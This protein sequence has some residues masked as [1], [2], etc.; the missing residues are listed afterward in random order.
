MRFVRAENAAEVTMKRN[1]V[2]WWLASMLLASVFG[3]PVTTLSVLW[4]VV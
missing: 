4:F 2:Y 1:A 3:N